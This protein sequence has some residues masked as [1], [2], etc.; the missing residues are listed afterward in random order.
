MDEEQVGGLV[1]LRRAFE[2]AALPSLLGVGR[3]VLVGD[4]GERQA[5]HRDAEPRAVHHHE[6]RR[7]AAMLLADQPALGAVVVEHRGRVAVNA[8][9]VFD[10]AA[11][12]AVALADAAVGAGQ[13]FRHEE[14]RNALDPGRRAVDAGQHQMDDVVGEVVLAGGDEDLLAGDGVGAVGLA[15]LARVLMRPRSVPQCGSVRFIVPVHSPVVIFGRIAR[16][17]LVAAVNRQRRDR[18]IG[19]AGVHREGEIGG[20]RIR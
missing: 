5:L 16:L 20:I 7:Q 2:R 6:H 4:L 18:A 13:E 1:R 10:R 12:D 15:G 8:H 17:Q 19:Q 9:L 11:D 3:G 14:E